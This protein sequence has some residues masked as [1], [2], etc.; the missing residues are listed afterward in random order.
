MHTSNHLSPVFAT[1]NGMASHC[2]G[3]EAF[4]LM[5]GNAVM[6]V[7]PNGIPSMLAFIDRL[8]DDHDE[9]SHERIYHLRPDNRPYAFAFNYAELQE[10]RQ[11]LEGTKAMQSL[12]TMV[13]ETLGNANTLY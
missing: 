9:H 8:A 10:L 4:Q 5:L 11:L 12:N 1:K 13:Q 6:T 2:V 7:H 3:C